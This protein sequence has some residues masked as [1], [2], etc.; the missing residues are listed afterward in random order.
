MLQLWKWSIAK[1]FVF[2]QDDHEANSKYKMF[3]LHSKLQV[4]QTCTHVAKQHMLFWRHVL[5]KKL[6]LHCFG[7]APTLFYWNECAKLALFSGS[8]LHT[9]QSFIISI[10]K[11][12]QPYRIDILLLES[13]IL[14]TEPMCWLIC[15]SVLFVYNCG[16]ECVFR[17][18]LYFPV[19]N[20][21]DC[22]LSI[23]KLWMTYTL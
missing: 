16:S 18:Q 13:A 23:S 7:G 5:Q 6:T 10:Q 2:G 19:F 11:V 9:F 22:I 15:Y 3:M 1:C 4:M 8:V 14:A 12:F 20:R 21:S 17:L